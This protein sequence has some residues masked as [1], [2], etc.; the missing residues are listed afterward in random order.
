LGFRD[1]VFFATDEKLKDEL[2]FIGEVLNL[3]DNRLNMVT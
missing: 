1:G 3:R 2:G